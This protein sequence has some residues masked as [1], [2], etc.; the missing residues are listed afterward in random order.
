[1]LATSLEIVRTTPVNEED[2]IRA[3]AS[4][5]VEVARSM[6]V[7]CAA[8]SDA[9]A[10]FLVE[11]KGTIA[12]G[13]AFFKK[14]KDPAKA[15]WDAV[16]KGEHEVV[17]PLVSAAQ[18]IEATLLKW[19]RDEQ[20]R[21]DQANEITRKAEQKRLEDA[22]AAERKRA[23]DER[24]AKAINLEET[25]HADQAKAVLDAPIVLAPVAVRPVA[26]PLELPKAEGL[27]AKVRHTAEVKDPLAVI[28]FIANERPELIHLVTFSQAS[29]NS[30][31]TAMKGAMSIPG[32]EFGTVESLAKSGKA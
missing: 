13:R 25:G 31:A 9:A 32:I 19:R 26:V 24:I 21:I 1:M 16:L 12:K 20:A 6:K 30:L 27:V 10:S 4:G 29:L 3:E 18:I 28:K 5:I 17:D 15:A 2:E 14:L 11:M 22:Q 7:T 8:E 23:E